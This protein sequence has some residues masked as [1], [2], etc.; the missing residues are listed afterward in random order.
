[1]D[2]GLIRVGEW[3]GL[4]LLHRRARYHYASPRGR[5]SRGELHPPVPSALSFPRPRLTIRLQ[6]DPLAREALYLHSPSFFVT[7][8]PHL[9]RL[10]QINLKVTVLLNRVCTFVSREF[11]FLSADVFGSFE[12]DP[13]LCPIGTTALANA[14]PER[15]AL[16]PSEFP[17]IRSS[18][19]LCQPLSQPLAIR[20]YLGGGVGAAVPPLPSSKRRSRTLVAKPPRS[21]SRCSSPKR[22]CARHSSRRASSSCTS[23]SARASTTTRVCSSVSRRRIASYRICRS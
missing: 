2:V 14:T 19:V 17:K 8:P 9:V 5:S 1:M 12:I 3:K 18:C 10:V 15:S 20:A 4:G 7:N 22:S 21:S 6:D 16:H 11:W 13:V 23:G